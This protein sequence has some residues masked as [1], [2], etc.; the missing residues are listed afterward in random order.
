MLPY[1]GFLSN[2][3]LQ[4]S[5]IPTQP[6]PPQPELISYSNTPQFST[7]PINFANSDKTHSDELPKPIHTVSNITDT[8]QDI[9]LI[10]SI[11]DPL[12]SQFSSPTP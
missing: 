6:R 2:T 8:P 4:P 9:S 5:I 10:S 7:Q 1:T 12:A 3:T 11:S